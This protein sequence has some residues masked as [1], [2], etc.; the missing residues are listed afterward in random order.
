MEEIRPRVRKPFAINDVAC[1]RRQFGKHLRI[2][3]NDLPET[4]EDLVSG[5]VRPA[6]PIIRRPDQ[7]L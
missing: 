2:A 4:N 5:A 1:P 7:T 6:R 3:F